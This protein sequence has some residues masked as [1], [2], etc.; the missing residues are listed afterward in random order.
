MNFELWTLNL[1]LEDKEVDL[2]WFGAW[3]EMKIWCVKGMC[4]V[5]L[6]SS[7]K[8]LEFKGLIKG[9]CNGRNLEV[10]ACVAEVD[11]SPKP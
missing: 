4:I 9:P 1:M 7:E 8:N 5:K 10:K 6:V 11:L 3:T 2:G